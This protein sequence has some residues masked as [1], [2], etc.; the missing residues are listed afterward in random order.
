[1]ASGSLT[2]IIGAT[3]TVTCNPGSCSWSVVNG[4]TIAIDWSGAGLHNVKLSPDRRSMKGQ[5]YD[6]DKCSGEFQ[7]RDTKASEE[8]HT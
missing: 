4:D 1:M 3:V 5:R 6:G 7:K 2:G 8:R